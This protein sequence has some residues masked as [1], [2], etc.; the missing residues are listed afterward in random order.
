MSKNI[1][2]A[3]KRIQNAKEKNLRYLDLSGLH[4]SQI[5]ID[6][7]DMIYLFDINLSF[8]NFSEFPKDLLKLTNIQILNISYNY[9]TEIDLEYGA[10]YSYKEINISNNIL[11]Y[12]PSII[13]FLDEDTE[14]IY[15]NN[16]F[17]EGLPPEISWE[18]NLSYVKFYIDSIKE[19]G[20]VKKLFEAKL[21]IVG[22]GDVGKTTLMKLLKNP[23]YE[24]EIGQETTT[25][26]ININTIEKDIY[27]PARDP[28]YN[29]NE[30]FDNIYVRDFEYDY[31]NQEEERI[32]ENNVIY[33]PLSNHYE[34][35]DDEFKVELRISDEPSRIDDNFFIRKELKINVWDF[36]G[37]EIM[38]STH[39]FFLT[40]RSLYLFIWEPRADNEEESFDYWL[41]IIQRVSNDSPV[42]IVMNK[43]D[44][45]VKNI[46]ETSYRDKF[47]NIID[48]Y[49]VSC[50]TKEGI[51]NL[52]K[53]IQKNI[54]ELPHIGDGLP[55]SWDDI[56]SKLKNL[57][58]DYITYDCFKEICKVEDNSLVN[59]L[60]GYLND[61]GDIIHL[62]RD[63]RLN[64]IVIIN[65]HWLT[66]A[67]Y[68]LIHTLE[69]Q[70]ND[71]LFNADD[72]L[73]YLDGKKYPRGKHHE[74]LLFM[75]N[76][77]ICFKVI[78]SKNSYVIPALLSPNIE[79]NNFLNEFKT[80][81][82]LKFQINYDFM[83][84][85]IIERI[86]CKLNNY[87]ESNNFWKYGVV[88]KTEYSKALIHSNRIEK[89]IYLYVT[90]QIR[91][92]LF[93]IIL[94]ELNQIHKDLKLKKEDL[95]EM[96]ACNC[97]LCYSSL[98]P[99]T[100]DKKTLYKF[101]DLGKSYIDCQ[102]SAERVE[103]KEILSGYKSKQTKRLLIRDFI[104]A[105]SQLQTRHITLQKMNEDE[106]NTYLNTL[107]KPYL[108]KRGFI[109]QEQS[110]RG[111]SETGKGIGELDILI[112]EIE[113]TPITIFEGFNLNSL[114]TSI[115]KKH[116]KKAI[117]N[118]DPNGLKEKY[119]GIYCEAKNFNNLADKYFKYI[120][121]FD[122][123]GIT[124]IDSEDLSKVYVKA[125]EIKVFR[126]SYN[127]NK[128]K[129][130]L[131]HI[132]VNLEL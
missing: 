127:R 61:I 17:L 125:P 83:P 22:K 75:E 15:H 39:Q 123:P 80:P 94:H 109:S 67:I 104:D 37:Q 103:I 34:N 60:S 73:I 33:E 128:E 55:S 105:F 23:E 31:E 35:F 47:K 11:N 20:N 88:F 58:K 113:G 69:V 84:S 81:E 7:S 124:I 77:D 6:I 115:I 42:I 32:F 116:L 57:K 68:Q 3:I 72:L 120:K 91:A 108:I 41:N 64:N 97:N 44:I 27:F 112:E 59:F 66:K 65:P 53:K 43:S 92:N 63:F 29:K 19:R 132:L 18:K 111:K 99:Y 122:M 46:D 89:R 10:Y 5:P 30:D 26:G 100:F 106:R 130:V 21:L 119:I 54:S 87:I 24:V 102:V 131:Y 79:G 98:S 40:K 71:G 95:R 126:T 90:G 76:F 50:I 4:L 51:H 93:N 36:G 62:R 45:R 117:L 52:I 121:E 13:D 1:D 78:G 82:S 16:P 56:R 9:L 48:F 114:A 25:H 110:R 107:L 85:G 8:N 12:I 129:L 101:L 118:Y 86:I 70:K 14:I 49:K 28:F 38:Y 2:T 96:L 74:I